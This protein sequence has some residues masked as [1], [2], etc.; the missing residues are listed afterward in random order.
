MAEPFEEFA[1]VENI[2]TMRA[3]E[4]T[5]C[6]LPDDNGHNDG[7]KAHLSQQ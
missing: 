7:A 4:H 1:A 2:E 5:E 3:H 6:H